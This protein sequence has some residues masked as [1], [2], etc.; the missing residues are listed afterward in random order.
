MSKGTKIL[1]CLVLVVALIAIPLASVYGSYQNG[2]GQN[3][4]GQGQTNQ[5]LPQR[6]R[7]RLPQRHLHWFNPEQELAKSTQNEISQLRF[8]LFCSSQVK[9]K[10][11]LAH[12]SR[13]S[14]SWYL[15]FLFSHGCLTLC[16][17]M[18]F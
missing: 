3:H 8:F 18:T 17:S 7:Q 10:R 5:R 6:L 14:F 9:V 15:L 1:I 12:Q 2:Q 11:F 4:N 16:R 13:Y